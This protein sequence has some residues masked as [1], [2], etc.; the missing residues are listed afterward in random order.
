MEF[1]N[2][3]GSRPRP[4]SSSI[5]MG[6]MRLLAGNGATGIVTLKLLG[7]PRLT[8]KGVYKSK[9]TVCRFK[10]ANV[11][12]EGLASSGGKEYSFFVRN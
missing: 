11:L 7:C 10:L 8:Q 4:N 2:K 1:S 9:L 12:S 5:C 3:V 6:E